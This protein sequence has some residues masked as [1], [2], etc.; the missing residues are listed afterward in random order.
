M[1]KTT[2]F[3]KIRNGILGFYG[4]IFW[5]EEFISRAMAQAVSRRP[6]TAETWVRSRGSLCGI[7]GGQIG[8]GAGFSASTSVFPC[9]FHSTAAPLQGKT[10]K[11]LIIFITGLH[12][13][14]QGCGRSVASVAGLFTTKKKGIRYLL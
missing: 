14:P 12:K 9:Q 4:G 7:C 6:L 13:K 8:T 3:F 2:E 1:V 10:E 5:F 11:K